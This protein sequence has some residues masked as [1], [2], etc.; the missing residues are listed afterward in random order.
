MGHPRPLR[1]GVALGPTDTPRRKGVSEIGVD[2]CALPAARTVATAGALRCQRSRNRVAL[3]G[4][5]SFPFYGESTDAAGL[6]VEHSSTA[7]R[8][9]L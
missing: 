1:G 2:E 9:W 7:D 3:V 4:A 6:V 8:L 5:K